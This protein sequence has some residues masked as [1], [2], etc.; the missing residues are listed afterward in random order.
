MGLYHD[1]VMPWE[2]SPPCTEF[3]REHYRRK[4]WNEG[5]KA[6]EDGSFLCGERWTSFEEYEAAIGTISAATRW[7]EAHPEIANT[8]QDVVKKAFAKIRGI[9]EPEGVKELCMV[10]P[11]VVVSLKRK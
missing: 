4:I 8:D 5:G 7:R 11:S 2:L 9:L 10:G 1:L 6:S 3:E